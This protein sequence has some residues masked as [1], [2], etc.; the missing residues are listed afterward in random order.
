ML[1]Q[2]QPNHWS[3]L[4]TAF[5]ISLDVAVLDFIRHIGHDGSEIIWPTLTEPSSRRGFHIQECLDLLYR[6][7]RTA[8]PF[9]AIPTHTP[10]FT[11]PSVPVLFGGSEQSAMERFKRIVYQT[12]GVITGI[13]LVGH[14]VA[15]DHG[16]ICDPNGDIYHY[17]PE[18]CEAKGFICTCAWSIT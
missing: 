7:G 11:V 15:Y 14:A 4:P 2:R 10:A 3:C 8:M 13:S 18:I 16:T 1:Y 17:S 6:L 12:H 9:E 5:A